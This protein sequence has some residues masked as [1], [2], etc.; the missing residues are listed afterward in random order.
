MTLQRTLQEARQI[1][2]A[3]MFVQMKRG[4]DSLRENESKLNKL[5]SESKLRPVKLFP[6]RDKD[7]LLCGKDNTFGR[8]FGNH[9]R[10]IDR[11]FR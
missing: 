1:N 3:E 2:D 8:F 5:S 10:Q 6:S 9:H 7:V 4:S 11:A